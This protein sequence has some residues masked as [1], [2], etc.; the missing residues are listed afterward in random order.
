MNRR[1]IISLLGTLLA[2]LALAVGVALAQSPVTDWAVIA[3]GG[4]PSTGTDVA[5]KDTL[6]Q[7]IIGPAGGGNVSLGA[8]YWYGAAPATAVTLH[9]FTAAVQGQAIVLTWETALEVDVLGFHVYRAEAP[10]A[11][12]TRLTPAL[13]PAHQTGG[14]GGSAYT[15]VDETAAPD[16]TYTYWLEVVDLSGGATRYGPVSAMLPPAAPHHL[17]L[18]LVA[19]T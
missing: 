16:I 9:S 3:G 18:P 17:Y 7:P 1:T 6:G 4:G 10:A 19:K 12:P 13:L 14:T 8:G 11:E 5:L 2:T 15:Y